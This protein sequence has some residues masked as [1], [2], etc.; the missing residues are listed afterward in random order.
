[1]TALIGM[2]SLHRWTWCRV[3]HQAGVGAADNH[4]Q[5]A[6]SAHPEGEV[7]IDRVRPE[8]LAI[9]IKGPAR[10]FEPGDPRDRAAQP[11]APGQGLRPLQ[12]VQLF[13]GQPVEGYQRC[14]RHAEIPRPAVADTVAR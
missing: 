2:P 5:S 13:Q 6:S 4:D 11:D 7:V 9:E 8:S 1:M 10:I 14:R 3:F 12:P